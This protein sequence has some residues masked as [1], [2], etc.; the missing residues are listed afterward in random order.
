MGSGFFSYK[1]ILDNEGSRVSGDFAS[2][3]LGVNMCLS[4]ASITRES[5][6]WR[7]NRFLHGAEGFDNRFLHYKSVGILVVQ[8]DYESEH[9]L[10]QV[11][12]FPCKKNM[13]TEDISTK[14]FPQPGYVIAPHERLRVEIFVAT[15]RTTSEERIAFLKSIDSLMVGVR[16]LALALHQNQTKFPPGFRYYQAYGDH[17]EYVADLRVDRQRL[18]P[19]FLLSRCSGDSGFH[20]DIAFLGFWKLN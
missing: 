17:T 20:K 13:I 9:W 5:S 4:S 7:L 1:L 2:V 14:N 19:E 11:H 15:M 12:T 8:R 16:G 3:L 10:E 18:K 6:E